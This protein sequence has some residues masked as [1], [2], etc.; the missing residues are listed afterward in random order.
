VKIKNKFSLLRWVLLG[1]GIVAILGL[2][3][4]NV[5]S[6]YALRN[7]AV[8][9]EKEA[10]KLQVTEFADQLRWKFI[11]SFSG[12]ARLNMEH[13][14]QE[15]QATGQFPRKARQALK[16]AGEYEIFQGIYYIPTHSE[17]CKEKNNT[18]DFLEF[19]PEDSAFIESS[20]NANVICDGFSM[21]KTRMK[22]LIDGY[23]YSNKVI[24]DTHRSMSIALIN[25]SEKKVFGYLVMPFDQQYLANEYLQPKLEE[26]FGNPEKSGVN[27][28]IRDWTQNRI[29]AQSNTDIDYKPENIKF[30]KK[31]TDFFDDWQL[32]VSFT[33]NSAIA[34]SNASFV[35]NL[36][37]LIAAFILLS[38]ALVFMFITAQRE[39]ALAERQAGF[40]ANVTHELKTPLAVMQAAGENLADGRVDN[41]KRLKLYGEHIHTEAVRLRKMI[42]KLLDVARADVGETLVE[43]EIVSLAPLTKQYI[44]EHRNYIEE[45]GF[46]LET[47]IPDNI[48]PIKIDKDNFKTIISNLVENAVKYSNDEKYINITLR[49]SDGEVVLK[50]EDHGRGITKKSLK[51][52]FEKFYRA[53]DILKAQIK[54]HGLGLSIVKNLVELNGGDIEVDSEPDKG[55]VFRITFPVIENAREKIESDSEVSAPT[56]ENVPLT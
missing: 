45:K 9:S 38:G 50:V 31:F 42:E 23:K 6:L 8:E 41:K 16:R 36:I 27:V 55:S 5:Y 28:W 33:N 7:N 34:A 14:Q 2:T 3:G 53:K 20:G 47:T 39:R 26:K 1:I 25:L 17:I 48:S 51:H 12:L 37:V 19:D 29:I 24:F 10:K 46:T 21:A 13:V 15:F 40:L 32:E 35:K 18:S 22:V 11:R 44:K 52:I 49:E 43:P 4:M 30:F 54:G 56:H